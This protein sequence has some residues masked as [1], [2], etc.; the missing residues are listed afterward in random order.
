M[1]QSS[2][3]EQP[4]AAATIGRSPVSGLARQIDLR[5]LWPPIYRNRLAVLAI[6]AV[7]VALAVAVALLTPP[8][9]RATTSVEVKQESQKV[10][11]TEEE[12]DRGA[13][14]SDAELF[15]QTQLNIIRSRATATA[16]ADSLRLFDNPVLLEEAGIDVGDGGAAASV[17]DRRRAVIGRL[18]DNVDAEYSAQTRIAE[19]TYDSRDP[20]LAARIANAFADGYIRLDLARRFDA[21]SYSLEFLRGQL[22]EAQARLSDSERRALAYARQASIIDPTDG[23]GAGG[24]AQPRSLTTATLVSLNTALA[25]ATAKRIDAEQQ[26]RSA[27]S[28]PSLSVPT[29]S[30]NAT[31][32]G[33][34]A[35]RAELRAQYRE[36]LERRTTENP[37]VQQA[38]AR[39]A[40]V[41]RQLTNVAGTARSTLRSQYESALAREN[42]LR[43]EVSNLKV[44]TLDEQS[45]GIRLTILRREADTNRQQ[46]DALLTRYNQLNAQSGVQLNNLAVIDRAEVPGSPVWPSLPLNILLAIVL[47]ALLSGLYVVMR[48]HL[49]QFV[50]T[51]DD[52]TSR[53][54]Y[55]AL[56][57]VPASDDPLQ[58]ARDPK[59]GLSEAFGALRTNLSL[60]SSNGVPSSLSFTS[61]RQGEGKST[62]AFG[63]AISLARIGKRVVLIDADLRRPNVHR[64]AQVSNDRGVSNLLASE[65]SLAEVLQRDALP[66]VDII[67]AGPVPPNP[68]ELL[69]GERLAALVQQLEQDYDQVLVDG[70]PLLG[71]AD[72]PLVSSAVRGTIFVIESAKTSVRSVTTALARLDASKVSVLGIVLSRFEPETQGYSYDYSYQYSYAEGEKKGRS[73]SR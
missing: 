67:V 50:R 71:L 6:M 72:A 58:D 3:D 46:L 41:E 40:E 11:G 73:W 49:L 9:Y 17:E 31:V 48:E 32:Q 65:A 15:L 47:G 52:V 38:A 39:L 57:T 21:S 4:A 61:A 20:Q 70:A 33:L 42:A 66:G 36:Q 22:R 63:L 60:S 18:I 8:T 13:T 45:R 54:G 59:T 56:G 68:A 16:V 27:Q 53:L 51:P 35:Q 25:E 64:L 2:T 44:S 14:G 62:V 5:E 69:A 7:M 26:W 29:V 43:Q 10:L 23:S 30:S 1:Y 55:P 37:L 24:S 28:Q 19:I 12:T 34:L